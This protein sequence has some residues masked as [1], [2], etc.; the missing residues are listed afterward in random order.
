MYGPVTTRLQAGDVAPDIVFTK[1]LTPIGG[2][3]WSAVNLTGRLSIL[4]FCLRPSQNP[5]IV[6]LWNKLVDEFADRP[7]QFLFVN[8]EQESTLEPSLSQHPIKGWVF[9]DPD[10]KTGNVYGLEQPSTIFIGTDRKIIGFG[11]GGIPPQDEEVKAALEGRITTTR[12]TRA[13]MKAFLAS[14]Q[15]LLQAEPLRF[16]PADEYKPKFP[17]SHELHVSPSQSEEGANSSGPD[18]KVLRRYTLREAI[19]N[20]YFDEVSVN[21]NRISLPTPLDNNKS[22]DF[23]LVLPE[24]EDQE[25][26]KSRMQQ[27]IEDYFHLTVR[28]KDRVV[29]AYVVTATPGHALPVVERAADEMRPGGGFSGGGIEFESDPTDDSGIRPV[30]LGV[31]R[32]ISYT[33]T[34]DGFCR[35]LDGSL[36]RPVIDETDSDGKIEIQVDTGRGD[37]NSLLERLREKSGLDITPTQRKIETLVFDFR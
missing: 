14:H 21:T 1:V 9:H 25:Q 4:V 22:Y 28:R 12:P 19:S 27:G 36:D 16:P 6:T 23:S 15:V 10:G 30:R 35:M 13:T 2:A 34:V 17:P 7:V 11:F 33:G 37:A 32:S 26:I 29:D 20:I 3:E 18:F 5:Q 31:V 24:A 8:G